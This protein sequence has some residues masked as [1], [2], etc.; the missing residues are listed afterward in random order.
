MLYFGMLYFLMLCYVTLCL[1]MLCYDLV[2]YVFVYV[3]LCFYVILCYV[4]LHFVFFCYVTLLF[5]M[6]C[7]GKALGLGK[8][9]LAYRRQRISKPMRIDWNPWN[10][11]QTFVQKILI[12][13]YPEWVNCK[14]FLNLNQSIERKFKNL[15]LEKCRF[16]TDIKTMFWDTAQ[17]FHS[18]QLK[19]SFEKIFS[20][21]LGQV[22]CKRQKKYFQ[23][24]IVT[25]LFMPASPNLLVQLRYF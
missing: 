9:N 16:I 20:L 15:P 24:N 14:V 8:K 3:R 7:Y 5:I 18:K 13:W 1:V 23:I 11:P 19:H 6:L 17:Y 25:C 10:P 12:S 21:K 22:G 2:F 4:V